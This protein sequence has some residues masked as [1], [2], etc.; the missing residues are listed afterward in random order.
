[1]A[2]TL[3]CSQARRSLF[4][5]RFMFAA[6]D[7]ICTNS[8]FCTNCMLVLLAWQYTA[9]AVC[10]LGGKRDVGV[11]LRL[12]HTRGKTTHRVVFLHAR[13]A[14]LRRPLPARSQISLSLRERWQTKSDGE[15]WRAASLRRPLQISTPS[16]RFATTPSG[17]KQ[18]FSLKISLP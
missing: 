18:T 4:S 10:T 11:S 6:R 14:S 16:R 15:G 2:I 13:A 1:M 5:L 7:I 8:A 9:Y 17:R 3:V 12:G